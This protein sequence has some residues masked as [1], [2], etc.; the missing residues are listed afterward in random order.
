MPLIDG[1][2]RF[3]S[4]GWTVEMDRSNNE[5]SPKALLKAWTR[6]RYDAELLLLHFLRPQ[7]GVQAVTV[8]CSRISMTR[9]AAFHLV[10]EAELATADL[11]FGPRACNRKNT[12]ASRS[13]VNQRAQVVARLEVCVFGLC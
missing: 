9:K 6:A 8:S 7:A 2:G 5:G 4:S 11:N 12:T 1:A 3:H 13:R 10:P